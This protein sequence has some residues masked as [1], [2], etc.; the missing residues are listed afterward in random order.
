MDKNEFVM[1]RLFNASN[2][3][4]WDEVI[5]NLMGNSNRIQ[6]FDLNNSIY[7]L[8]DYIRKFKVWEPITYSGEEHKINEIFLFNRK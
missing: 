1:F 6:N 7:K 8:P 3:N 5:S 2:K 4:K